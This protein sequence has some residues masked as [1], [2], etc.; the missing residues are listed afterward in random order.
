MGKAKFVLIGVLVAFALMA[1]A[2]PTNI[3]VET[4]EVSSPP[5][6]PFWVHTI[7]WDDD[8]GLKGETYNLYASTSPITQIYPLDDPH[9]VYR[10]FTGVPEDTGY[11]KYTLF[12][13]NEPESV[14]YYYAVTSVDSM[15]VEN[16]TIVMGQNST[17]SSYFGVTI[18]AGPLHFITREITIDGY[19]D[20][21]EDMVPIHTRPEDNYVFGDPGIDNWLDCSAD[22]FHGAGLYFCMDENNLYYAG[23]VIDDVP[24]S[25]TQIGWGLYQ[26]DAVEV[27]MGL[28]HLKSI[29]IQDRHRTHDTLNANPDPQCFY[30]TWHTGEWDIQFGLAAPIES[31]GNTYDYLT[32]WNQT[33]TGG[34]LSNAEAFVRNVTFIEPYDGYMFELRIPFTD[35]YYR[36][37]DTTYLFRPRIGM[38][39]PIDFQIDDEDDGDAFR[40]GALTWSPYNYGDVSWRNPA[41]WRHLVIY[42]QTSDYVGIKEKT[43]AVS[44]SEYFLCKNYPDPFSLFTNIEYQLPTSGNVVLKI[45]NILGQEVRT[46]VNRYQGAGSY[47]VRWDGR[48]NLG[49]KVT[50]GVYLYRLTADNFASTKKMLLLK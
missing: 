33:N 23:Y 26:D 4:M 12:T 37:N 34:I 28:Y 48:N 20:E 40:E 49:K 17:D 7:S 11:F 15:G 2:Q 43:P 29:L 16:T 9:G 21:Y 27:F 35:F 32:L 45:Y 42:H 22:T 36:P 24:V 18:Y 3:R 8:P 50:S 39:I 41:S 38:V 6:E 30:W 14:R 19:L 13:P 10:I 1:W 31:T 25:G 47:R 5:Q 44:S 46:L